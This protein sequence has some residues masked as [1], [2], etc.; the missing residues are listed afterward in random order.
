MFSTAAQQLRDGAVGSYRSRC[1]GTD[2]ADGLL[3]TV[4]VAYLFRRQTALEEPGAFRRRPLGMPVAA[5]VYDSKPT[6][7]DPSV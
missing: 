4:C 1:G 3:A 6:G 2:L 7:S 5:S